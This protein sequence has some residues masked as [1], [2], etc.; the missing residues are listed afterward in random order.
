MADIDLE[1]LTAPIDDA[2]PCGPDLEAEDDDAYAN[3]MAASE[4]SLPDQYFVE[5]HEGNR[6][7]FFTEERFKDMNLD[8]SI[9]SANT[10]L[11]RT[12]DLRLLSLLAKIQIFNRKPVDFQRTVEVI[13]TLLER[14]W[15]VLHPG[16][17]SGLR[18]GVIERLNEQYTVVTALNNAPL[19]RSRRFGV[20]SLQSYLAAVRETGGAD[21]SS[22]DRVLI[23]ENKAD[24][25]PIE[26]VQTTFG[27][28]AGSI[29]RIGAVYAEKLP[30]GPPDLK[31]LSETVTRTRAMLDRINP[32]APGT[33]DV[34]DGTQDTAPAGE[35]GGGSATVFES[36]AEAVRALA[37]ATRY[38]G[39][40]EPSSP[41][42]LLL[43][44]AQ[45][46]VGKSFL[47]AMDT[48]LPEQAPRATMSVAALPIFSLPLTQLADK[49]MAPEDAPTFGDDTE[50]DAEEPAPLSPPPRVGSRA[51]AFALLERV[52]AHYR[53]VE[54]SSPIPL[55][56]ERAR[57]FVGKDFLSLIRSMLPDSVLRGD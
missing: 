56:I 26:A 27:Q 43:R 39:D 29:E 14:F 16:P 42:L 33:R 11:R 38:I 47:E 36:T 19:F 46:L 57:D 15:D 50:D 9:A 37:I 40:T 23:E 32:P 52:G 49:G 10:F 8:V 51:E 5:D 17:A 6:K 53:A 44:Q 22:V 13:A 35:T 31:R 3:F 1:T 2:S 45:A 12:H 30:G 18:S 55:L 24:L 20:I 4:M 48:L 7:P 25:S 54:P 34:A 41:S 21:T 28:L